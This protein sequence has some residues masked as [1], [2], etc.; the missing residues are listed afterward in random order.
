MAEQR[1]GAAVA[2]IDVA[3]GVEHHDA[4]GRGVENGAEFLGIGVADGRRARD[5]SEIGGR[6]AR[7]S[8]AATAALRAGARE[9]QRQ[10][11]IVVPGDGVELRLGGRGQARVRRESCVAEIVTGVPV[12]EVLLALDTP[13]ST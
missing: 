9:N 13:G 5:R 12:S 7:R 11:G 2:G 1:F 6:S 8:V 10:R 3:L 4:F